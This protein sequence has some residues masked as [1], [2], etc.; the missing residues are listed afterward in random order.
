MEPL[1]AASADRSHLKQHYKNHLK[2]HRKHKGHQPSES[3]T[4]VAADDP[5]AYP[6]EPESAA[7]QM[8]WVTPSES[9]ALRKGTLEQ[10]KRNRLVMEQRRNIL[11]ATIDAYDQ[12]M[13]HMIKQGP[14]PVG[15]LILR[16][17]DVPSPKAMGD[18]SCGSTFQEAKNVVHARVQWLIKQIEIEIAEIR[19]L[20]IEVEATHWFEK[21]IA[22]SEVECHWFLKWWIDELG[23]KHKGHQPSEPETAVAAIRCNSLSEIVAVRP[24]SQS[25]APSLQQCFATNGSNLHIGQEAPDWGAG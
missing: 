12:A 16:P 3:E 13:A 22:P 8:T 19:E 10:R 4:A 9:G 23:R 2:Q 1:Q 14:L 15:R 21:W 24:Q 11:A 18:R 6:S 5:A 7:N 17:I 25:A 20:E